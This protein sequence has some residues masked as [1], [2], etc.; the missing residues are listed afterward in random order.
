MVNNNRFN[1]FYKEQLI[2]SYKE[3]YPITFELNYPIAIQIDEKNI[4]KHIDEGYIDAEQTYA[5][6]AIKK[7]KA[8]F[9]KNLGYE[10]KYICLNCGK[11]NELVVLEEDD[12]K[13]YYC[14]LAVCLYGTLFPVVKIINNI[15]WE[16]TKKLNMNKA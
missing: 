1:F 7:D 10:L 4:G 13:H 3:G 5:R 12:F 11:E 6:H 9:I 2:K 16:K 14:N 8:D 15:N